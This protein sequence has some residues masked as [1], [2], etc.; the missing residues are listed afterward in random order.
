MSD[1]KTQAEKDIFDTNQ[2]LTK[3]E[4]TE[5][6]IGAEAT[7]KRV[8]KFFSNVSKKFDVCTN[9]A[10]PSIAMTI[11]RDAY[12][13]MKSRGIKIRW[14]TDITKDNLTHCKDLMQYAEVRY[15]SY[16]NENFR[17]SETEYIAATTTNGGFPIPKLNYSNSKQ[18]V[19]Q[20]QYI[21]EALWAKAVPAE[22][23][24][25]QIEQGA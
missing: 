25:R 24:I 19:G 2:E 23:R 8:W 21:F 5:M 13:D 17:V 7:T 6:L 10:A 9:S 11:F 14:V 1:E 16:V 15:I 18:I 20:Q 22:H 4:K 3:H 12:E